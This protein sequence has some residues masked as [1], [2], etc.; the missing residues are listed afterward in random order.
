M[1]DF[2]SPDKAVWTFYSQQSAMLKPI[3]EIVIKRTSAAACALT[4]ET[5]AAAAT[6][7]VSVESALLSSKLYN[8]TAGIDAVKAKL[9]VSAFNA[10]AAAKGLS[11]D[12][13]GAGTGFVRAGVDYVEAKVAAAN[14]S[15]GVLAQEWA[16]KTGG[17]AVKH[18][19]ERKT[20]GGMTHHNNEKRAAFHVKRS[21]VSAERAAKRK[22]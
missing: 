13:L 8:V 20:K 6:T 16:N 17:G 7:G 14:Y 2:I 5:Q 9:N 3:D 18:K 19:G 21:A 12:L 4:P 10:T 11:I 15:L 22:T 1:I